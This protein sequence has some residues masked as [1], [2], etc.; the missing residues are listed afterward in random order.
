MPTILVSGHRLEI[1][2]CAPASADRPTVVFLHEGLGSLGLWR[3]FPERV[4]E[5]TGCGTLVYSRWGYGGSEPRPGPWPVSFMHDEAIDT[6]PAVLAATGIS[7]PVLLGHSDGGSIALIFAAQYPDAV[8]AVVTEAAHVFV[9]DVT[10]NSIDEARRRFDDGGLRLRLGRH[11]R[12]NTDTL[13]AGW[14]GVWRSPAFRQW[15][16]RGLLPSVRCPVL[17]MQ[18]D[19]DEYGT[20]QQLDDLAAGV[21]GPCERLLLAGCGH[22]PHAQKPRDVVNAVTRFLSSPLVT[23]F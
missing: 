11:H 19:E 22:A 20:E 10:V 15:D 16:I 3:N 9:E 14:A 23:A 4:R 18:G 6:L 13:F 1:E 7:R 5:A 17:A 2:A 21:A 8:S 12:R